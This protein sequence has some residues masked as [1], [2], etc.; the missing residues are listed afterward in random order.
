MDKFQIANDHVKW[1]SDGRCHAKTPAAVDINSETSVFE[2]TNDAGAF[3]GVVLTG[4]GDH[5][6]WI[7][8]FDC[9]SV[10]T[11]IECATSA[12]AKALHNG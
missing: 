3:M 7:G 4:L 1:V 2:V 12:T 8:P 10:K 6:V 11:A 9:W 5:A